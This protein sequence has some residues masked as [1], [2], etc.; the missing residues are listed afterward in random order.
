[1]FIFIN[2]LIHTNYNQI[3]YIVNSVFGLFTRNVENEGFSATENL[4]DHSKSNEITS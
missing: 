1:M 3:K 2:T 4:N